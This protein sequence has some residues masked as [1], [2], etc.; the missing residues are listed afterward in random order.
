MQED[1][2]A[3]YDALPYRGSFIPM[4]HPDQ[5]AAM[6]VLHGMQPPSVVNCRVL[7][8]GCTDGVNLLTIAQS[9]PN[10]SFLGV[11]LSPRQ[12]AEGQ[13]TLRELGVANIELRNLDLTTI[14]STYGLFDYIICHGVYSWVPGPVRDK[15]LEICSRSLAPNGVAF[16]SYNI[17]PGWHSRMMLR[18]L[19]LYHT[20]GIRDPTK[21]VQQARAILDLV[22]RSSANGESLHA[23]FLL[24]EA[25]RLD[26]FADTYI[27]HDYLADENHPVYFHE[28]VD[29][30]ASAGLRHLSRSTFS[31]DELRLSSEFRDVISQLGHDV[32]RREQYVDHALCRSFRQSLLCHE[33][34]NISDSPLPEAICSLHL[35]AASRPLNQA[36]DLV[37][38]ARE[39]FL[40]FHGDRLEVDESVL[41]S[42]LVALH[43]LWPRSTGF[44]D[45]CTATLEVVGGTN[46]S[47]EFDRG[48]FAAILFQCHVMRL[49]N[50]QTYELPIATT[51]GQRPCA[52]ALARRNASRGE[53]VVSLRNHLSVLEEIDLLVLPLLDGSRDQAA[54]VDELARA[55]E[56]GKVNIASSGQSVLETAAVDQALAPIVKSSLLRLAD[57]A[58]LMVE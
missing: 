47:A 18:D 39:P 21:R 29:H 10:A 53:R 58:L 16:V 19:M 20:E 49:L 8:L 6:A 4:T 15:I 24:E 27:F 43:R 22:S 46:D 14:D 1:I 25:K 33:D 30:A 31:L 17:Y 48:E 36:P 34:L 54:I 23:R 52:S 40:T 55:V 28:F 35:V 26:R 9:L 41:K 3:R 2:A 51:P 11:D 13:A 42:A 57:Q 50:V 7:E 37:T 12:V 32:V 5:M 38:E 56:A 45:L 44:E